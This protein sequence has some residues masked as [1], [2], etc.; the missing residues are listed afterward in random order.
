M[1]EKFSKFRDPGT[2]IQVFLTPVGGSRSW[3]SFLSGSLDGVGLIFMPVFILLGVVR[4][5]VG[6]VFWGMYLV[7]GKSALLRVVL[8]ALGFISLRVEWVSPDTLNGRFGGGGGGR[9]KQNLIK[10][11][12]QEVEKGDL[13]MANHSSYL[14]LVILAWLYPGLK[15]VLPVIDDGWK[16]DVDR[17]DTV[18]GAGVGV[19]VG[20]RRIP[21]KN[22]MSANTRIV[23]PSS[24][25]STSSSN[26]TEIPILGYTILPLP[27]ALRFIGSLPPSK[28][29]LP[30]FTLHQ[31]LNSTIKSYPSHP[32]AFFPEIV[33][34]NNRALLTLPNLPPTPPSEL[35][36]T[37]I[38]TLK[39]GLPTGTSTT[40]IYSVPTAGNSMLRHLMDIIFLS[41]PIRFVTIRQTTMVNQQESKNWPEDVGGFMS[42]LA[43]LKRTS[44]A[45]WTKRDFLVMV[46]ARNR[47]V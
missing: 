18:A 40:S 38:V 16:D 2:G 22:A 33:T 45:W 28:S 14:D 30:N 4:G 39:Y 26:S 31:D 34:S 35:K 24:P 5:V 21:K 41:N 11:K 27:K 29:Q 8:G 32:L 44:I 47:R 20:M 46:N 15:F 19:G 13:V 42:S 17:A 37:H 10:V 9:N 23:T 12:R 25:S 1:A 36:S 3:A 43:R 7:C 6:A